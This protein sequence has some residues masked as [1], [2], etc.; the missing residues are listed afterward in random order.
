[1]K[2]IECIKCKH[3]YLLK[4]TKK[5]FRTNGLS[6]I[7][8]EN[9]PNS[10]SFRCKCGAVIEE[11]FRYIDKHITEHTEL[12]LKINKI[13]HDNCKNVPHN[14]GLVILKEIEEYYFN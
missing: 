9:E 5:A 11:N 14:I 8:N 2:N 12:A 6:F 13:V 7:A 1:M 3:K 10:D 4:K